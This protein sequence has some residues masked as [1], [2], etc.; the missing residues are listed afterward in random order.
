MQVSGPAAGL[1]VMVYGYIQAFGFRATCAIVILPGILQ[2]AAVALR[3]ARAA[4]ATSPAVLQA[5]LA[6]IGVLIAL[7]QVH[8][9]FGHR[10]SG[11][12]SANLVA[13]PETLSQANV[14]ATIV[15]LSPWVVLLAW[16]RLVAPRVKFV[17][18]SLIAIVA[19]T[20]PAACLPGEQP[21]VTVPDNVLSAFE[22]PS[23]DGTDLGRRLVAALGLAFVASAESLLCAVATDRLHDGPRAKL[24]KELAAQGVGNIVS[25]ALGGLPITG[26]IVRS[27]ANIASGARSSLSATVHG[28]WILLFVALCAGFLGRIPM[29]ALA[30]LLVHVGVNLAKIKEFK[31]VH[32]YSEAAV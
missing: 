22:W 12:A 6:G 5:M 27:S 32:A 19:G 17:P 28:V 25:G 21:L 31:R 14:S 20:A 29:A 16:N 8:V 24:N 30:A 1:T 2:L 18:G 10:P 9:L 4:L 3:F 23:I 15:G 13:L 11:S 7:G 26:V